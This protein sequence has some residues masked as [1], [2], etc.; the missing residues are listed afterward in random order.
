MPLQAI[1]NIRLLAEW[2]PLLGYARRFSAE[3]DAGK[4]N[5]IIGDALEWLASKTESLVDDELAGHVAA[6]LKTAEGTALVRWFVSLAADL[7]KT[8]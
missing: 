4:R 5:V 2:A 3:T 6:I 7:E 1:E 8:P